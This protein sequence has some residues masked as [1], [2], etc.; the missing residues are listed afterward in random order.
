MPHTGWAVRYM[1]SEK[2][3]IGKCKNSRLDF[4]FFF[5]DWYFDVKKWSIQNANRSWPLRWPLEYFKV[6]KFK[7]T[8]F[9][10]ISLKRWILEQK[11]TSKGYV[12]FAILW[13]V[14][15]VIFA[16]K[17]TILEILL[18]LNS[19]KAIIVYLSHFLIFFENSTSEE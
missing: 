10:W 1:A 9:S 15:E 6:A 5:M 14:S 16:L 13:G 3:L 2:G 7:K 18:R 8:D 12:I 17:C 4:Q 11:F 19:V